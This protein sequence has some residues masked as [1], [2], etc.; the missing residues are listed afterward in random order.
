ML[1]KSIYI[2]LFSV[3]GQFGTFILT[4]L[5]ARTL[6]TVN[7]G[8][9]ALYE[10]IMTI[11]ASIS[12]LAADRYAQRYYFDSMQDGGG[13]YSFKQA[14]VVSLYGGF[15][16]ILS[17]AVYSLATSISE[18]MLI[19]ILGVLSGVLFG[20]TSLAIVYSQVRDM[21][22]VYGVFVSSKFV[23]A[24][25]MYAMILY[26][27]VGIWHFIYAS[28]LVA[29]I[30]ATMTFLFVPK[31]YIGI[32]D[33][34]VTIK[35]LKFSG[36]LI[37]GALSASTITTGGR[38]ILGGNNEFE[39]LAIYSYWQKLSMGYLV[40][41]SA[42]NVALLPAVYRR[43]SSG[44]DL[45]SLDKD[46]EAIKDIYLCISIV[47]L[48]NCNLYNQLVGGDSF[49]SNYLLFGVLL[50]TNMVSAINGAGTDLILIYKERT[51]EHSKIMLYSAAI[52]LASS[53]VAI[54]FFDLYGPALASLFSIC[55]VLLAQRK[56]LMNCY[57][58]NI[59]RLFGL[60]RP[61]ALIVSAG[62][63]SFASNY[64][65]TAY[66]QLL[67]IFLSLICAWISIKKFNKLNLMLNVAKH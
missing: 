47:F 28:L 36:P 63:T 34:G 38:L 19:Y 21:T 60:H 48:L 54:K 10:A 66:L 24:I 6:S 5:A 59:P 31:P 43:L 3:L 49:A 15:V 17:I 16:V 41:P 50:A 9:F 64:F 12:I 20:Y 37:L 58:M 2:T 46:L 45:N 22:F 14:N 39:N 30:F 11:S 61:F 53:F 23:Y 1:K 8:Q 4:A 65:G 32:I 29:A 26:C 56:L 13:D 25:V 18:S 57:S 52:S 7:F 44:V 40:V 62:L 51:M 33:F 35:Y 42:L 55:F 27:D 67:A